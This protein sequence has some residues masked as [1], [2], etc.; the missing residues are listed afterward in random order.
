MH[1]LAFEG[2]VNG[3]AVNECLTL[4]VA[5]RYGRNTNDKS[6]AILLENVEMEL[7]THHFV[8]Y[9]LAR[10]SCGVILV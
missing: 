10:N 6:V 3:A 8:N 7:T 4:L 1:Y 9:D 5:E 2:N